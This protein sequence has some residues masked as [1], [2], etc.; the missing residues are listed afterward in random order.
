VNHYCTSHATIPNAFSE[1]YFW[2]TALED[3]KIEE[4]R[5]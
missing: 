1:G 3:A 4:V 5:L 2:N